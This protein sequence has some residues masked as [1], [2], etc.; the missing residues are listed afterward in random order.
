MEA[1]AEVARVLLE[2]GA[3]ALPIGACGVD[4]VR[5]D[6]D[7]TL[8]RVDAAARVDAPGEPPPLD[9]G[10]A[11]W[12]LGRIAHLAARIVD[13]GDGV[14]EVETELS[15]A[16]AL[17]MPARASAANAWSVDLCL[18]HLESLERQARGL[19]GDDPVVSEIRWLARAW[20]LSGAALPPLEPTEGGGAEVTGYLRDHPSLRRI[21]LDRLTRRR[22]AV[23]A[24]EPWVA[25]ALRVDHGRDLHWISD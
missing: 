17:A 13:R 6:H 19:R 12:G 4:W 18:R 15:A 24:R 16:R 5:R 11:R 23:R 21:Y 2:G 8:E 10:A 25:A 3:A 7:E 9:L 1:L 22:C 14:E 20:P